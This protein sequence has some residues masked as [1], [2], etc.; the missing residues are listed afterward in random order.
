MIIMPAASLNSVDKN[1]NICPTADAVAPRVM[2][3]KEKPNE[4]KI[5][6]YKTI[7]LS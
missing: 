4:N 6:L 1:N 3:T 2:N 7:F 5:V